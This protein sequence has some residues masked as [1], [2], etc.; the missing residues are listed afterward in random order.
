MGFHTKFVLCMPIRDNKYQ[1]IGVFQI[2]NRTDGFPF[3]ENDES[4]FE[5]FTIF[6]GLGINNTQNYNEVAKAMARQKVAL[7]VLSYHACSSPSEVQA[8][9]QVDALAVEMNKISLTRFDFD[10]FMLDS[11]DM[12]RAT[13]RMYTNSGLLQKFKIDNDT[14][15]RWLLTVR[16]NYRPVAYHNFRH[17]FNVQQA[18]FAVLQNTPMCKYLT[19][20]EQLTLLVGCLCHDLDHR[21]TNN[22]FQEKSQSALVQLYGSKATMEYHHFNHAVMIL[23]SQGHNIF[24]NMIPEQYSEVMNVLKHSILATDL[25]LHI[26]VRGEFFELLKNGKPNWSNQHHKELLR[27]ML[28]TA[29]DVAASTKPWRIQQK[30]AELV[31]TEFFDQGDKERNELNL[32]PTSMF[33]RRNKDE[34]PE[35]QLGFLDGICIPL[36]EVMTELSPDFQPMLTGVKSNRI[37]WAEQ[38]ELRKKHKSL[39]KSNSKGALKPS[40]LP[41]SKPLKSQQMI[42]QESI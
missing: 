34:L 23:S 39:E 24:S 13:F 6:C 28:M 42:T 1:I 40:K 35:M 5:A 26:K 32:E 10:D 22:A 11:D 3:D 12:L 41:V 30:I 7:E 31:T 29:C 9:Q 16:K 17:A 15:C 37:K 20:M 25:A 27:G 2:L 33:D 21:G 36:Y 38:K 19:D 4:L 14:M 18:M 8:V